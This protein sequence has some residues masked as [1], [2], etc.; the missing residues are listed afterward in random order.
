MDLGVNR[1]LYWAKK[2][3]S[4]LIVS[5]LIKPNITNGLMKAPIAVYACNK[6]LANKEA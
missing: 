3:G 5:Y 2:G 4:V 6:V 1:K